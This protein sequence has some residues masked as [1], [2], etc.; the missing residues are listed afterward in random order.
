MA[1]IGLKTKMFNYYLL[2]VSI[3]FSV[4]VALKLD[5][6]PQRIYF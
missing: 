4:D 1:K 3:G 6:M 5:L 2:F